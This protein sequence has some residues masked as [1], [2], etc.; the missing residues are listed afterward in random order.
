MM[1][2]MLR[3]SYIFRCRA[4]SCRIFCPFS[5]QHTFFSPFTSLPAAIILITRPHHIAKTWAVGLPW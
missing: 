1:G 3:P 2:G 5:I 4:E